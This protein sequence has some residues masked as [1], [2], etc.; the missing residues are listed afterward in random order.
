MCAA[1]VNPG[2]YVHQILTVKFLN[3]EEIAVD[4]DEPGH[5]DSSTSATEKDASLRTTANR[6]LK[7][8]G[9]QGSLGQS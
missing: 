9:F 6:P 2:G 3:E 7:T 1:Y 8:A 5:P 4:L